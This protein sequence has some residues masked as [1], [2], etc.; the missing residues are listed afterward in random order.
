M[1][2]EILIALGTIFFT[3]ILFAPLKIRGKPINPSKTSKDL[4]PYP[5]GWYRIMSSKELRLNIIKKI[6]CFNQDLIVYRDTTGK[7]VVQGAYC[8]HLGA[9]LSGGKLSNGCIT[10]PF[11]GWCF[12]SSGKCTSIPYAGK[13]ESIPSQAKLDT[14]HVREVNHSIYIW[15]AITRGIDDLE[16]KDDDDTI[17]TWE[18]PDINSK[19]YYRCDGI[20]EHN[21]KCH[22]QDIAENGSDTRHFDHVH[23]DFMIKSLS[24]ILGHTWAA[25][26]QPRTQVSEKHIV[27]ILVSTAFTLFGRRI[28]WT[29]VDTEIWQVG[30]QNVFLKFK[31]LFGDFYIIQSVMP[32][33]LDLQHVTEIAYSPRRFPRIIAKIILFG[34]ASQFSRDAVIWNNKKYVSRPLIVKS[35]GPIL[36]F[37]RWMKQFYPRKQ[38]TVEIC[39][40]EK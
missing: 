29:N 12:D 1:I 9:D 19:L 31:T 6:K 3:Y 5:Q 28:G 21:I 25:S 35:D 18:L 40:D 33:K 22:V 16:S 10:C 27:D 2:T 4:P 24:C 13:G 17:P 34:I 39:H 32:V 26:W 15:H 20:A 30:P 8:P 23:G 36:K 14:W 37:R 38:L 7:A 11:H